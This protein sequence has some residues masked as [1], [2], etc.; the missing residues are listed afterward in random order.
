MR[1]PGMV[2][3]T[4]DTPARVVLEMVAGQ[5]K[6]PAELWSEYG[7]RAETR[8]EHLVVLQQRYGYQTFTG[9]HQ[10]ATVDRLPNRSQVSF[11]TALRIARRSISAAR[12]FSPS[13][14]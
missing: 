10:Q 7:D 9:E 14:D 8:H 4:D 12:D 1:F 6:I 5:L 11:V 2:L 13:D 3:G